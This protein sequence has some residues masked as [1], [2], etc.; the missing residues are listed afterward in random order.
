LFLQFKK[1]QIFIIRTIIAIF[2]FITLGTSV[3][4]TS[5]SLTL[6]ITARQCPAGQ[7]LENNTCNNIPTK[8]TYNYL[9]PIS[10]LLYNE[11]TNTLLT[12]ID[13]K[14]NIDNPPQSVS[15]SNTASPIELLSMTIIIGVIAYILNLNR[16]YIQTVWGYKKRL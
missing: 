11:R 2:T 10:Q 13:S 6:D 3:Y 14:L 12:Q 1:I 9:G 4:A 8:E 16:H 7:Y 15:L 5:A